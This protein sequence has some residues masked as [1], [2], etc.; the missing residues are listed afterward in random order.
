[1]CVLFLSFFVK[2]EKYFNVDWEIDDYI[3]KYILIDCIL[4]FYIS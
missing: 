4:I 2:D 1:M 3:R